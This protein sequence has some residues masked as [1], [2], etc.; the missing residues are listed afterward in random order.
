MW[1]CVELGWV[2]PP[3]NAAVAAPF[4]FQLLAFPDAAQE[5]VR[6][7]WA[8]LQ[9]QAGTKSTSA[10]CP[11]GHVPRKWRD[12]SLERMAKIKTALEAADLLKQVSAWIGRLHGWRRVYRFG[13]VAV[14]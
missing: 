2:A 8:D 3:A 12:L 4:C 10:A 14:V 1:V 6:A 13:L 7:L 9:R 11:T 5:E